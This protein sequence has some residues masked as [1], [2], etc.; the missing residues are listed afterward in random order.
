[1]TISYKWPI[2][3]NQ[4]EDPNFTLVNQYSLVNKETNK[5]VKNSKQTLDVGIS[6]VVMCSLAFSVIYGTG[7]YNQRELA[8]I[9]SQNSIL[10]TLS[11][12]IQYANKNLTI[13]FLII[14][15]GLLQGL[16]S[17]QNI[18]SDDPQKAVINVLNY[19]IIICWLLFMFI[20]PAS[21]NSTSTPGNISEMKISK[22]HIALAI[23]VLASIIAN[24]FL[25]RSLYLQFYKQ[26]D[27]KILESVCWS[28]V[29]C[30]VVAG[31]SMFA[32]TVVST[33]GS[34]FLQRITHGCIA[35]SELGCIIIFI[36]FIGIFMNLPALPN[37]TQLSCVMK[38]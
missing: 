23:I 14:F 12:S 3:E 5:V 18:Y 29:V 25:I 21:P 26:E 16:F 33:Y 19:I 31:L 7:W 2:V 35:F 32:N 10:N 20:W 4:D 15:L 27:L 6:T 9:N 38:E 28:L 34:I 11:N 13:I 24:C 17:C 8:K 36:V 30:S 22:L 37:Q 1:M